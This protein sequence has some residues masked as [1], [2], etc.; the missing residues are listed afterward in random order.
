MPANLTPQYHKAEQAYRSA[1]PPQEEIACLEVMLREIP[2]HK[3]TDKLQAELKQKIARL[4]KDAATQKSTGKRSGF[5]LPK[6]G[7]GR[8]VLIGAPNA[9]KS[10][11]LGSL[12]RAQPV[13]A[14]YPFSTREPLPG[15]MPW[16][17]I[18]IQVVDTPPITAEIL[19]PEVQSLVRS[20]DVVAL[21][22]DLGSDDGGQQA[23]D[24][25]EKIQE[26]KTRLASA[27]HLDPNDVGISYTSCVLVY[28]KSDLAEAM[29]RKEFFR[30]SLNVDWE[31]FVVSAKEKTGLDNFARRM[32]EL[33]DVIRVYTKLPTK[34]SADFDKPYTL[35]RGAAL[36]DLARLI[37]NDLAESLK[38][39]RVWGVAVHDGTAVK[40]DYVLHDKDIVE[41]HA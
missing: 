33:L 23:A 38:S 7:A 26:T 16:E 41:I 1:A 34:K 27:T 40:G 14:D 29:D 3:G 31:E 28:N 21:V 4:K 5:R 19:A 13:I 12:T 9:G 30:D 18:A 25:I 20:A 11:L 24:V 17:D 39:A 8:V 6:Q 10:Q 15:M 32:Y 35:P 22:V 37:H 2:K 36:I